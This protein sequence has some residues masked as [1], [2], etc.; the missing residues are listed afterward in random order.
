MVTPLKAEPV[1]AVEVLLSQP[2]PQ[3]QPVEPVVVE[4]VEAAAVVPA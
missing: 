2:Q 4:V 1:A 3:E